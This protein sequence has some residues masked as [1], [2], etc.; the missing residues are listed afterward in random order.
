[1][2]SGRLGVEWLA[3][4]RRAPLEEERSRAEQHGDSAAVRRCTCT[5]RFPAPFTARSLLAAWPLDIEINGS[6]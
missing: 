3:V 4:A 6:G 1:L 5:S 2:P